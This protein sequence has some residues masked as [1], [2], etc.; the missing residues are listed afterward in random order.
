M[1]ALADLYGTA[2]K[3]LSLFESE[4]TGLGISLPDRRYVSPGQIPAWD[5]EQLTV[6]LIGVAQGQPGM[7]LATSFSPTAAHYHAQYGLS[8]L[9]AVPVIESE[10]PL[11]LQVPDGEQITEASSEIL[12]DAA[13]LVKAGQRIHQSYLATSAGEGFMFEL[14]TV[15]PEGGLAGHRLLVT[16]SVD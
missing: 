14:Q 11:M 12:G 15:G 9:R 13:A 6:N 4:L 8:L 3:L 16:L 7:P 1:A 2:A 10:G 5:G